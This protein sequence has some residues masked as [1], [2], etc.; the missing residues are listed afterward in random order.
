MISDID[1][2][3]T[4]N[5][6]TVFEFFQR[7][8]MGLYIPLYQREYSWDETNIA[9]LLEDISKGIENLCDSKQEDKELRFL[10]TVITIVQTDKKKIDPVDIKA[11]PTCVEYI[12][13]G[14]QRLTTIVIFTLLLHKQID[15]LKKS[16]VKKEAS[17]TDEVEEA[18]NLWMKKLLNIFSLDLGKG[19]IPY[20]PQI[21]RGQLDKWT[22]DGN[23]DDNYKSSV[24]NFVANYLELIAFDNGEE[25]KVGRK[26]QVGRNYY[27]INKWIEE[28]V[29]NAHINAHGDFPLA[30]DI[31]INNEE[32]VWDNE[33]PELIPYIN[34]FNLGLGNK[35]VE[36]DLCSLVQIF[37]VCHYL[38]ERCCFTHIIPLNEDWA[39]DM[40]QS[41]NASGTPLTAIETFK[42]L[43]VNSVENNGQSYKDSKD[44]LGFKK[45]ENLFFSC[46]SAASKSKRTKDILTSFRIPVDGKPLTS[47]FSSQRAWLN[48][49]YESLNRNEK[50]EF[51][52]FFGNYTEFYNKYWLNTFNN[53]FD[54]I[55]DEHIEDEIIISF[56]L[57]KDSKHNMSLTVLGYLYHQIIIGKEN[58][59]NDF[60]K[61]IE[62]LS[63]FYTLY[64][65][66]KSN[67]GLDNI[68]RKY[69]DSENR[70]WI[71][72]REFDIQDFHDYLKEIIRGMGIRD[73]NT[74]YIKAVTQTNYHNSK[75]ICKLAIFVSAEDTIPD[76]DNIGLFKK[77]KNGT[78]HFLTIDGWISDKLATIEHIA[79]QN[80]D[81]GS[82]SSAL[83][84]ESDLVNSLG[85]LTLLPIN[86]NSS[87][88]NKTWNN[89]YFYYKYISTT[90]TS[91]HI[92]IK[93][94][95]KL[96]GV[97]LNEDTLRMLENSD[98]H[99]HL[100]S[101][102]EL[103]I[104]G[105]WSEKLVR[106]RT[107]L[108]LSFLWE[109]INVKFCLV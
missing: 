51:I 28:E 104:Y 101:I 50:W 97:I 54:F 102:S 12:I 75:P 52:E 93:N 83:Y 99:S 57:L 49:T 80:N 72:C 73:Y 15:K 35:S 53:N 41:L 86:L 45:I 38:L 70:G 48:H 2:A 78:T 98:Y 108:M 82:W 27:K 14:Q 81:D 21:I 32:Y 67:A 88:G 65:T 90:D 62:I 76:S 106:D 7:P 71:S 60:K 17:L 87:A 19:R 44:S 92:E 96:N 56:L 77:A 100:L 66:I 94:K 105:D 58:A 64:R 6:L 91:R 59:I 103:G 4:T 31:I 37:S 3:F 85:N 26:D 1:K 43:V 34:S 23:V 46:K 10:G 11:V 22:K 74:W 95:A 36:S 107:K 39:F 33:R 29:F 89:K 18:C 84:K 25:L 109:W 63:S 69:F 16:I 24:S 9:Q 40:F 5:G 47:H 20:K 13:D 61:G 8:G 68:Y 42:P 55:G 79:P 30:K